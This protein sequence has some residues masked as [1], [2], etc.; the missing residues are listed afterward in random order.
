MSTRADER[1]ALVERTGPDPGLA[2][3]RGLPNVAWTIAQHDRI[4]N[5]LLAGG[6]GSGKSSLL[7]RV[8]LNDILA[9]NTATVVLDMKGSLSARLL[10]LTPPGVGKRWWDEEAGRWQ[11]ETKRVWYLDLGRPAFGLTPLRVEAPWSHAGL[12]DEF[13]RIADAITRALL[14]L[15]PGQILGSSEDLIERAVVGAMASSPRRAGSRARSRCWRGCSP[16]RTGSPR[17]RPATAGAAARAPTAGT[18]PPGAPASGSRTW[19]RWR[20]RCCTKFPARRATTSRTSPSGWRRPR[21]R[22]GRWSAPPRRS[23]GSWATRSDCRCA[24]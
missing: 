10:R 9:P 18:R 4:Y 2:L 15:Y 11:E 7:L 24:R 16:R 5:L 20:T 12:A 1:P 17:R 19:T 3:G 13:A 6:Q 21:T 23:G 8:A 22:S 14:D